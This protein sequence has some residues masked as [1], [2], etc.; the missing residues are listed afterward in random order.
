MLAEDLT[1]L[2]ELSAQIDAAE[3][4]LARLLPMSPFA[5][6]TTPRAGVL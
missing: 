5:T 6:L 4:E 3:A 2:A 1:L